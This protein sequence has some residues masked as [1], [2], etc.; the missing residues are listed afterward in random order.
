MQ[1]ERLSYPDK[2]DACDVMAKRLQKDVTAG[3]FDSLGIDQAKLDT[4]IARKAATET[5]NA[6]QEEEKS[7]LKEAT[8]ELEAELGNLGDMYKEFKK[9]I[10]FKK[11]Q[12]SWKGYS[13]LDKR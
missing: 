5:A 13:V 12:E 4:F 8:V 6:A 7:A 2:I 1:W 10:K 9:A 11:P 3:E